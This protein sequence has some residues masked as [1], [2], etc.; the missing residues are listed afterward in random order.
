MKKVSTLLFLF[1]LML[2]NAQNKPVVYGFDNIPQGLLL[3]PGMETTYKAHI[4]VPFLSGLH[5]SFNISG[6]TLSD[7]FTDDSF[8]LVGGTDFN[9]KLRNVING[10]D[11]HD[12]LSI[13]S[14][15]EILS[16]GY[17]IN[18]D[19]YL[20][21][22]FYN[23]LDAFV[24]F[25]KDL[26]LLAIDGN[27]P[28]VGNKTFSAEDFNVK[29]DVIGVLHFGVAKKLYERLT[30][31]ARFKIYS[32]ALSVTS[33]RN[34]GLYATT[35]SIDDAIYEHEFYDV[36]IEGNT[37][38]IY[39]EDNEVKDITP[40]SVFGDTFLSK[41]FGLGLDFGFTYIINEQLE[42]T[43]SLLDLGFLTYTKDTR[44]FYLNG[45]YRFSGIEYERGVNSN[46]YEEFGNELEESL[47]S[48]ENNDFYAVSR[49]VKINGSLRYS[50]GK[51]RFESNCHDIRQKDYYDNAVGG[52]LYSVFR[53]N[54]LRLAFT[55]FYERKFAD[56]L[57]TKVTWTID[58]FS[59][60]NFG[61]GI[62]SRIWKF[63]VYGALNNIFGLGD[64]SETHTAS[65]Q[66]GINFLIN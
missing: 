38:G 47:V 33:T 60:T 46:Y 58:D 30:V 6:L 55:G 32:G 63:N 4:G 48:N 45:D 57:N 39:N 24:E 42:V 61:L 13:N 34:R 66:L 31:G 16:G 50:F 3:N 22:G 54:G 8:G 17:K 27:A 56:F 14:Q 23:E 43:G 21:A 29:A 18:S 44:N 10:L 62:S 53:P 64:L 9:T 28:Y 20:S 11:H 41:N 51:S 35:S 2:L 65:A 26:A 25:P 15:I 52:Q 59:A 40:G 5:A 7:L 36:A 19:T 1:C 12:Y 37:S 49:P